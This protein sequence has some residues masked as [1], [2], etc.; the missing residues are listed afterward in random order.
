LSQETRSVGRAAATYIGTVVGAGFASGQ[1]VLQFFSLHG[2]RGLPAIFVATLGFFVYGL[3]SMEIGRIRNATSH[4]PV[5]EEAV[6]RTL[7]PF[8]DLVTTFFLFGALSAMISGAGSVLHQEFGLPWTVG[9]IALAFVTLVT[10]LFGLKGVVYAVSSVVPF[11]IAGVLVIGVA[12][13][14]QR[15]LVFR[16][17]PPG[18]QPAVRTWGWSG[19]NYV[20]Y[21]I[22]MAVP[23]LAALGAHS[24]S[25]RR[26]VRSCLLGAAGLGAGLTV[27]YLTLVV[28]FPDSATY[29]VPMARLASEVHYLG[30]PLYSTIFLSEVY[31]TAVAN[32]YGFA[33][34]IAHPE[35]PNFRAAAVGAVF[36]GVL[37]ASIGF[38]NLVRIVYPVV[39]WAG[40]AFLAGLTVYLVFPKRRGAKN[41]I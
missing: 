36:L 10:V 4:G 13:L 20:S 19:V 23:V 14:F 34:R 22:I 26:N 25:R 3:A 33:A 21:N 24:S 37:T 7:A 32:L 30:R 38:A 2:A 39:G 16:T 6:G 12:V 28:S 29:E 35:T 41:G 17:P 9:A 31:T 18:F 15:G 8:L 1:E 40:T 27:V 11:L 5:L